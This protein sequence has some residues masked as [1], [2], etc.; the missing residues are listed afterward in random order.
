[1]RIKIFEASLVVGVLLV[2]LKVLFTHEGTFAERLA[3]ALRPIVGD[4]IT[5]A[6]YEGQHSLMVAKGCATQAAKVVTV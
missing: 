5:F 4:C 3:Y 2:Y 6:S 1:M